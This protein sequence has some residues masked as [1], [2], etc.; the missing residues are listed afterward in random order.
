MQNEADQFMD[1]PDPFHYES[2]LHRYSPV[3]LCLRQPRAETADVPY[4][5]VRKLR[6]SPFDLLRTPF[7]RISF[8]RNARPVERQ[9]L[10]G[11]CCREDAPIYLLRS[12]LRRFAHSAPFVSGAHL[13]RGPGFVRA[14]G[15]SQLFLCSA[16]FGVQGVPDCH[17]LA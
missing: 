4:P 14:R 9:F 2:H 1:E 6:R 12:R 5:I 7:V 10:P 13:S 15:E 16:A 17:V 3:C 11:V 8:Q